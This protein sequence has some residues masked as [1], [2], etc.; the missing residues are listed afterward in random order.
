MAH[1][2]V[3][4]SLIL[5]VFLVLSNFAFAFDAWTTHPDLTQEIV[6]F[7]NSYSQRKISDEELQL[8]KLGSTREDDSP[9]WLNHFYDPIHNVGLN[10]KYFRGKP[11]LGLLTWSDWLKVIAPRDPIPSIR[12]AQD[13]DYQ[14]AFDI[15]RTFQKAVTDYFIDK[16]SAFISLGHILHLLEDLG[17]PDHSRG[18]G[19]SG[20]GEDRK[21]PYEEF[22]KSI[23]ESYSLTFTENLIRQN[24]RL[25][26]FSSLE[27]VFKNLAIFTANNFFSEDT[28]LD[29]E[30]PNPKALDAIPLTQYLTLYFADKEKSKPLFI[31]NEK[32]GS[33]TTNHPLILQYWLKTIFPEIIKHG[34]GLLD[35]YFAEVQKREQ[36]QTALEI[37]NLQRRDKQ[38]GRLF[39]PFKY[40]SF[41]KLIWGQINPIV[42]TYTN[43][44]ANIKTFFKKTKK[45]ALPKYLASNVKEIISQPQNPDKTQDQSDTETDSGL[46]Y[47][48]TRPEYTERRSSPATNGTNEITNNSTN[49]DTTGRES[50]ANQSTNNSTN[51]SANNMNKTSNSNSGADQEVN[52]SK[53]LNQSLN[54]APA[55]QSSALQTSPSISA[56]QAV[57]VFSGG[58]ASKNPCDN[59]KNK[60]FPK[61]LI[62]EIQ[63]ETEASTKDEFIEL[64]NPNAEP[65]ELKCWQLQKY[66][67]KTG[68]DRP[69]LTTLIPASKFIGAL[70]PFGFF[71]ISHPEAQPLYGADLSYAD[72]YS[73]AKNNVVILNNPAGL[74]SD[75]VGY[76]DIADKIYQAETAPFI[77]TS[78]EAK[79]IQRKNLIDADNN[80]TDFWLRKA[81]P[82]N[83]R[84]E[85]RQPREDFVDLANLILANPTAL[86]DEET[87]EFSLTFTEPSLEISVARYSYN[88]TFKPVGSSSNTTTLF[89]LQQF[90]STST[91][92]K[93]QF[94]QTAFAFKTTLTQ[95]PTTDS[96]Y[97]LNLTLVDDLDNENYTTAT[98]SLALSQNLCNPQS[99]ATKDH[100]GDDTSDAQVGKVVIAEI[101][102]SASSSQDEYIELYNPNPFSVNLSGWSLIRYAKSGNPQ[103]ILPASKFKGVIKPF[104]F[105]LIANATSSYPTLTPDLTYAASYNLA[106]DNAIELKDGAGATVDLVGWGKAQNFEAET[107]PDN[108]KDFEALQRKAGT[109]STKD[110]LNSSEKDFGNLYDTNNNK[111]DFLLTDPEPQNSDAT[112]MPPTKPTRVKISNAGSD[113]TAIKLEFVSP[114][115]T[116]SSNLGYELRYDPS[117]SQ[118]FTTEAEL[119]QSWQ[120]LV[121]ASSSSG[122]LPI[123]RMPGHKEEFQT[124]VCD[125]AIPPTSNS[126]FYLALMQNGLP[127]R[128][129]TADKT[130]DF[131]IDLSNCP[132][133]VLYSQTDASFPQNTFCVFNK[134]SVLYRFNAGHS[135]QLK[136][137]RLKLR[138]KRGTA[139]DSFTLTLREG[140]FTNLVSWV[141]DQ[142][143]DDIVTLNLGSPLTLN[144]E[145]IY[146]LAVTNFINK[147]SQGAT[148]QIHLYFYGTK[149]DK[150]DNGEF[151]FDGRYYDA[152]DDKIE[153]KDIYFE[154]EGNPSTP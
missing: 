13:E 91:L 20:F 16:K 111:N 115:F 39:K 140:S 85:S 108:P 36:D 69:S 96:L 138:L 82:E 123:V 109:A 72:S 50:L 47:Q 3:K 105:F 73:I 55:P 147:A 26:N 93:P 137:I 28:V 125:T 101:M 107:F 153:I 75:L 135:G 48:E 127:L 132:A 94:K 150:Y 7:F 33:L 5:L 65:V 30:F 88:L 15:N 49:I 145:A 130:I 35:L 38:V 74:I 100:S 37:E 70:Q 131:S 103:T 79:S 133:K 78:F 134:K 139:D 4:I 12:W 61:L 32:E 87:A 21:S 99:R 27:G 114:Y 59:L 71:L 154:L 22:A 89:T 144:P 34:K 118:T 11:P 23:S 19:H 97:I 76:G 141:F 83:S 57:A 116:T 44:T 95:C 14:I 129:V 104:S 56:G 117:G 80:Q 62:S 92:P 2:G 8:L 84:A 53:P 67:S 112:E 41:Q 31:K 149:E 151:T 136:R 119:L 10:I 102:L 18:D 45:Q 51:I 1:Q 24:E 77:A 120:S 68:E 58:E 63:F 42:H 60:S 54:P 86:F 142:D 90:G 40:F 43:I 152:C 25:N 6:K 98:T 122:S 110:S 9:R 81:K 29:K 64:Y 128:V 66:A 113:I 124:G 143:V 17:V 106:K 121:V 52:A 126:N 146:E 148:F 46:S